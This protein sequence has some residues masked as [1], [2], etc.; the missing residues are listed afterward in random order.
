MP[1]TLAALDSRVALSPRR[2]LDVRFSVRRP[3]SGRR[4]DEL[5]A[6]PPP[7]LLR[8]LPRSATARQLSR[9]NL[10]KARSPA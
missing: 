8:A 9:E 4:E 6:R 7:R 2:N 5:E 3:R 1:S 10:G